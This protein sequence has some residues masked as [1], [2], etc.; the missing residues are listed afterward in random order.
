MKQN[1]PEIDISGL[2]T[3]VSTVKKPSAVAKSPTVVELPV[4]AE[5]PVVAEPSVAVKPPAVAEPPVV[6]EMPTVKKPPIVAEVQATVKTPSVAKTPVVAE[7]PAIA[8][9]PVVA[10]TP[11]VAEPPAVAKPAIT[12]KSPKIAKSA[13]VAEPPLVAEPPAIAEPPVVVKP[14]AVVRKPGKAVSLSKRDA[15]IAHLFQERCRQLNI[16][17]FF[18]ENSPVRSLGFTSAIDGEGKSFLAMVTA[19]LL[20]NDSNVPVTLV[21]LQ[22][23][24]ISWGG[25]VDTQGVQHRGCSPSGRAKSHSGSRWQWEQRCCEITGTGAPARAASAF[26]PAQ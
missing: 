20:A 10:E 2:Q 22:H 7:P 13:V 21:I 6:A 19:N 26:C 18:Q 12:A 3:L 8:K 23:S 1:L 25:G 9:L 16:S 4:V 15:A 11:A 14:P 5:T 24:R 17:T